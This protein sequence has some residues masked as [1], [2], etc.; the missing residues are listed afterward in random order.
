MEMESV[1]GS[2]EETKKRVFTFPTSQI[3]LDGKKSSYYEV[4]HSCAFPE[5]NAALKAVYTRL[6]MKNIFALVDDTPF[7]SE[8][9]KRF[10]KHMLLA[11]FTLIIKSTYDMLAKDYI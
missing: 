10:Y 7:I 1:M 9:H 4:I 3:K 2:D 5:C 11:R 6:E 8:T